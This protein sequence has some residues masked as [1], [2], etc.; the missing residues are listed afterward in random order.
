MESGIEINDKRYQKIPSPDVL[1][2]KAR[3]W[4]D[5]CLDCQE[6][7]M[8]EKCS[9]GAFQDGLSTLSNSLKPI[10][11][12]LVEDQFRGMGSFVH[13]FQGPTERP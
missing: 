8:E 4:K 3:P 7:I 2:T 9:I 1:I 10:T 11:E 6:A 5:N 12:I 13:V